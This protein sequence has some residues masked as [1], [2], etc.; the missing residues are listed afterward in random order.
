MIRSKGFTLVEVGMAVLIVSL[1]L[2]GAL[3]PLSTQIDVRN[4]AET[5]RAME[6]IRDAIIGFT[7]AQGRLPCPADGTI[8]S[9]QT[10]AGLEKLSGA[11]CNNVYGVVPWATLGVPETDRWGRRFS[12]QITGIF[13]D[14]T[15]QNTFNFPGI[16][17]IPQAAQN[18][19]CTPVPQ[20]TQSSFALCTQGNLTVNTRSDATHGFSPI[21]TFLPVVVIS[22]GKNGWGAYL[23]S[24]ALM[25]APIGADESF[26]AVH[27]NNAI[28]FFSRVQTS[29][30]SG[31]ND[32]SGTFCEFDD[33]VMMISSNVLVARMVAAGKLP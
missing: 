14:A 27:S 25:G 19:T 26:N 30:A 12:Y 6:T 18:P 15:T 29:A 17:A 1:L 4:A 21:G 22:H 20:P 5:Q 32:A 8:P 9:G 3:I 13:G 33:I 16:P 31:C 23:P 11:N 7:Q 2:A 24:G 28:T 10:N